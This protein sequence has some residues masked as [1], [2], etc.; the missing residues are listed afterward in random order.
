[1]LENNIKMVFNETEYE[2]GVSSQLP[3][4]RFHSKIY[5]KTIINLLGPLRTEY[6][7]TS[8]ATVSF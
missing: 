6:F 8:H 3:K 1:M 7:S 2:A 5:I 4:D